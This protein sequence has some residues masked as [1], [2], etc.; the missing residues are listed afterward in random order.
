MINLTETASN[1]I[2]SSL[3]EA[4]DSVQGIRIMVETGGCA[5][6]KY[7]MALA[8]EPE[9]GDAVVEENG[10]KVFVEEN[11]IPLLKGTKI[12]FVTSL[13]ESGFTFDNPNAGSKCSCGKS[14]N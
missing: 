2:R 6:L 1:A 4:P 9:A 13:E 11:S 7:M 5:G 3:V 12:D 14:F 8:I 10:F